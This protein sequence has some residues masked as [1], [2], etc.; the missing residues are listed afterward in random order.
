MNM[1]SGMRMLSGNESHIAL[2]RYRAF[3]NKILIKMLR[4]CI[5]FTQ[6]IEEIYTARR[7]FV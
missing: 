3:Q 1:I 5:E 2:Q 6:E 7:L 4:R